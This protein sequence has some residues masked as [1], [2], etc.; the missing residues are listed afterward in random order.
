MDAAKNEV[1]DIDDIPSTSNVLK[2]KRNTIKKVLDKCSDTPTSNTSLKKQKTNKK[3]KKAKKHIFSQEEN[4]RINAS[5]L[6]EENQETM[7]SS[8]FKLLQI[9]I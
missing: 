8:N 3:V 7:V 2:M 1:F 4:K 5:K 9:G 6:R